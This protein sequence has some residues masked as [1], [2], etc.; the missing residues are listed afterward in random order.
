MRS[1]A[2]RNHLASIDPTP[3]ITHTRSPTKTAPPIFCNENQAT[4]NKIVN[5]TH[6]SFNS[7]ICFSNKLLPDQQ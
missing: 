5:D 3:S 2:N 6:L 4:S 7:G 1:V